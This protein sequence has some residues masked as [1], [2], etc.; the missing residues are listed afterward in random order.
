[1]LIKKLKSDKLLLGGFIALLLSAILGISLGAATLAASKTV[2]QGQYSQTIKFLDVFKTSQINLS[3]MPSW[4]KTTA[5]VGLSSGIISILVG[6]ASLM[7][8]I[9]LSYKP[10]T[11]SSK[12][13]LIIGLMVIIAIIFGSIGVTDANNIIDPVWVSKQ[14]LSHW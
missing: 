12:S 4:F 2:G 10:E 14:T 8:V 13:F 7:M 3:E 6:V 11:L 1:M 9:V 5:Y